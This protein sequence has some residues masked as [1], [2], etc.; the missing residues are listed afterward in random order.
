M[1]ISIIGSGNTATVLGKLLEQNDHVIREVIGHNIDHVKLL[2][3]QLG[4]AY[5]NIS[6]Q[7]DKNVDLF[8]VALSDTV[9]PDAISHIDFENIPVIHTAGAVNADV[10]EDLSE[11]YGVLY[12]LQ[13]LRKEV[14]QIPEIPF[15]IDANNDSTFKQLQKLADSISD[16]VIRANDI[17]RLKL[18]AGAVMVSNFTNYL[19]TAAKA[20]CL[21][22]HVDFNLLKP[23]IL[24]TA[25]RLQ[26]NEPENLQTGPAKRKDIKTLDKHLKLLNNHPKLRTLYMRMT[27]SIMNP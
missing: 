17:Q 12:P 8:L 1:N 11:N 6:Q 26:F 5:L 13:S 27:D 10:L 22:E 24:E 21:Q 19:Y 14:E 18:N 16:T 15:L 23:L 9:L 25:N 20:F 4:A 7:P 2:S 3:D